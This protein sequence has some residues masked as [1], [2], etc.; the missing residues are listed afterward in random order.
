[1]PHRAID[2]WIL[3]PLNRFMSKSSSSG[4]LLFFTAFL[5]LI[6]AN[7]PLHEL[8]ESFWQ[9]RVSFHF[10]TFTVDNSL[11]HWVDDGLMSFFFF[12]V[13]LELKR[14]MVAG[15]LSRPKDALM[16]I[17]AAVGGMLLPAAIYYYF[18]K[19]AS[20]DALN[21]WG[22]PMATDI[23]F[24][25]GVIYLLGD[26]VPTTLKVFLTALAIIDDVGAVSIIA[27]FYTDNI[28]VFNLLLG[29]FFLSLMVISNILGIRNSLFYGILGIGGVWLAFLLSGVH[30]TIAAVL[31]AFTIPASVEIDKENYLSKLSLFSKKLKKAE[32]AD[33]ECLVSH[34][35]EVVLNEIK[36]AT[37]GYISPLQRLEHG[38]HP[39]VAFVVMPIFALAN[40]GV[41]IEE[42]LVDVLS[43]TVA[44]GVA[45]GLIVGKVVGI[46]GFVYLFSKMKLFTIPP[47][48]NFKMILGVSFLAAIGF[49]MS[50]FITSLAFINE[51]YALQAK[52]GVLVASFIAGTIGFFILRSAINEKP[53]KL[54]ELEVVSEE[55]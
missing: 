53:Q 39:L 47:S 49:T 33:H 26:K 24:A 52:L 12:V 50:L 46:V 15:E 2:G 4:I 43:G 48:L 23:A 9:T 44:M 21:G 1:M 20:L 10:G 3:N 42:N 17:V 5:S 22:I 45:F 13:G 54:E 29:G 27:F 36:E 30:A 28:S 14:E 55:L 41:R 31:A 18:N 51:D 7:S 8:F 34:K 6:I 40:A 11:L 37:T 35:E 19:D 16:A 32:C 25:L 38:M